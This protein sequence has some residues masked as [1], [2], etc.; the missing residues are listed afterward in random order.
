MQIDLAV[1]AFEVKRGANGRITIEDIVWSIEAPLRVPFNL[2]YYAV[3]SFEPHE[4]AENHWI[5]WRVTNPDGKTISE[6]E[7][8]LVD[9]IVSRIDGRCYLEMLIPFQFAIEAPGLHHV[10]ITLF[11]KVIHVIKLEC[12]APAVT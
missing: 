1:V 11:G 8:Q 12:L 10:S 6:I 3:I 2:S 4:C 9:K 5:G 7:P